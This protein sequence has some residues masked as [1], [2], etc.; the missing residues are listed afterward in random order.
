MLCA[1]YRDHILILYGK[2]VQKPPECPPSIVCVKIETCGSEVTGG[3]SERNRGRF[4]PL[5]GNAK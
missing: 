3:V 2:R 4:G 1:S 5:L